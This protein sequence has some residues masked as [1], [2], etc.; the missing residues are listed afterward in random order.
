MDLQ[1]DMIS[2]ESGLTDPVREN[3]L[4]D[5]YNVLLGLPQ[6]LHLLPELV[7]DSE[8]RSHAGLT[9]ASLQTGD[10]RLLFLLHLQF[11]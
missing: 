3:K 7:Q 5:R 2:I 10:L 4:P 11:A 9:G 1:V 8:G 6:V